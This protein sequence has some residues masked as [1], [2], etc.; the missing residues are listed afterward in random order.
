MAEKTA[1]RVSVLIPTG[2]T[3][4]SYPC[5]RSLGRHGVRTIVAS[6]HRSVPAGASRFCDERVRIPAPSDDL[7]AYKDS[8]KG[9]AARPNVRTIIPTRPE[10]PYVFAK[11]RDEFEQYVSLV[12]PPLDVLKTVHDRMRLHEAAS[13]AGIPVPETR[14]LDEVDEWDSDYVIKSRY[15]L[16]AEEYLPS[17]SPTESDFADGIRYVKS[18]SD[19]DVAAIAAE[20]DHVPIAQE[21]VQ[22]ESQY[23][24][25]ALYDHGEPVTTFQHR[26]IRGNTYANGGGVYRESIKNP[27]LKSVGEQLLDSLNWHGLACVEYAKDTETGEYKLLEINPRMW[28]SL[29]CAVRAGADFPF[30]YWCQ[31]TGRQDL[32]DPHYEVGVRSHF[33]HGELKHLFSVLNDEPT[34]ADRPSF[35]GRAWEILES[36]YTTPHFDVF[37]I[38]DPRPFLSGFERV[39]RANWRRS[40]SSDRSSMNALRSFRAPNPNTDSISYTKSLV[41]L[42]RRI[43]R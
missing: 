29:P 27:E 28:Q 41:R 15:N 2:F 6:E 20:M 33:L 1:D 35:A 5:V 14:S 34:L 26:Q 12:V 3:P 7:F 38:D 18:G 10:D 21:Y 32:I 36:C 31:A 23:V 19:I 22:C 16:L 43:V 40:R 24:F 37:R 25:G 8:L 30:D 9:I 39:L 42:W 4:W 13:A 17:Y 11:Y